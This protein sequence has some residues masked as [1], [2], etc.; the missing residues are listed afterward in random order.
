VVAVS[1][2]STLQPSDE[3]QNHY[4]R[5]ERS[6]T[7][8][9]PNAHRHIPEVCT[10]RETAVRTEHCRRGGNMSRCRPLYAEKRIYVYILSYG[11]DKDQ[12]TVCRTE[13]KLLI[14]KPKNGGCCKNEIFDH[15]WQTSL[16]MVVFCFLDRKFSMMKKNKPT[17][18]TN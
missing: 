8:T 4:D 9:L 12:F 2:S 17:K 10:L 3:P 5:Y 6:G 15:M 7:A 16:F 11:I 18:C 1:L 13:E 14:F